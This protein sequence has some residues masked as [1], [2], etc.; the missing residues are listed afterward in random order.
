MFLNL[1]QYFFF[2]LHLKHLCFFNLTYT[3]YT[4]YIFTYFIFLWSFFFF[5]FKLCLE[6][7]SHCFMI[8]FSVTVAILRTKGRESCGTCFVPWLKNQLI[9]F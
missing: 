9:Y 5:L 4:A 3:V 2:K 6:Y 1:A 7:Q 8:H